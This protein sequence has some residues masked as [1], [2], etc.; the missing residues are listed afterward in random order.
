MDKIT[1]ELSKNEVQTLFS[2]LYVAS[3]S[4]RKKLLEKGL[5][6]DAKKA[7][8]EQLE[9]FTRLENLFFNL[10]TNKKDEN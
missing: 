8:K 7:I 10:A 4:S 9:E 1:I 2:A 5:E 6:K 3:E